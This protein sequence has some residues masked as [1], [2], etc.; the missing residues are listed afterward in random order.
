MRAILNVAQLLCVSQFALLWFAALFL[1]IATPVFALDEENDFSLQPGDVLYIGFP[2]EAGFNQAFVLDANGKIDLPELGPFKISGQKLDAA[3]AKIRKLMALVFKG[4]ERLNVSLKARNLLIQV[5][6]YVAQPGQVTAPASANVQ[7]AIQLAGGLLPGAQLD[8]FQIQRGGRTIEFNYKD[9]LDSGDAQ[10]LPELQSL[11]ILFIPASPLTGNVQ[12]DFDAATLSA[13]GDAADDKKSFRIFGEVVSPGRFALKEGYSIVDA[14]M[15]AGGVTRYAGV[16][17]I[18][19][20]SGARPITFNL[21]TYLETGDERLMPPVQP[22]TTIFVPIQE[23]EIKTG[24]NVVYIMGEVF[25]P[26]A[27]ENKPE[28]TLLDILANAGGPTRF[29]ESRQMRIL[30]SDGS[31]TPFDLQAYTEGLSQSVLP[32]IHAGDAIFIPEKTD[33]NEASWLKVPPSRAIKIIGQ[34]YNPGRYEW[35]DE[36]S[37]L[38]I[39]AHAEGPTARADTANIRIMGPDGRGNTVSQ[40]FNLEHFF[41]QG[42]NIA[43]LPVIRAGYT[44]VVPELPQDPSDNKAQW[45]RQSREK[46]IYIMGQVGAPGRYMFND[47]LTFLDILSAANGPTA[48]ADLHRIR[49]VHRNGS[50]AHMT[51]LNLALYFQTGDETLLPIVKPGDSIFVP[52]KNGSWLDRPKEEMIRVIG[53]VNNPGRYEFDG[54][55]TILDLLAQAG[56]T[57]E[58]AYLNKLVVVNASCCASRSVAFDLEAFMKMPDFSTLPVLRPGDTLFI[59]AKQDSDWRI[60]MEG[61]SDVFK[62]ISIV[63]IIG[64]L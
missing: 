35:S 11:D 54:E 51:E 60:F 29:A 36:M 5:L 38:D 64:V 43:D 62:L 9:Y 15:R 52:E 19:I 37:L 2:G 21:K 45:V 1:W 58:G 22:G 59:P 27:Y 12:I 61:V 25:K 49:I 28:A 23:E 13:T 48:N 7:S 20:I 47:K 41:D 53:A 56:G 3:E 4:T 17:Q 34:V 8:R 46:S 32:V 31:V 44:I 14:I 50:A 30:R 40:V 55:M 33:T 42:G 6:G 39:I 26:G 18:K 57:T 16:E 24:S 63:A 10:V